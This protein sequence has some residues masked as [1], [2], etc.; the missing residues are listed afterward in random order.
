MINPGL[1]FLLILCVIPGFFA[2][3]VFNCIIK[4]SKTKESFGDITY[5]SVVHSSFIYIVVY[6]LFYPGAHSLGFNIFKEEDIIPFLSRTPWT[7]LIIVV[8]ILLISICYGVIYALLYR[9]ELVHKILSLFFKRVVEPP[10]ILADI[11]DVNYGT[12]PMYHWL[13]FKIDCTLYSGSITIAKLD[14]EPREFL[15]NNIA[16]LDPS[17]R[18]IM[19]EYQ[20]DEFIWL[21]V[22]ENISFLEIKSLPKEDDKKREWKKIIIGKIIDITNFIKFAFRLIFYL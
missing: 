8:I 22:D 10:N 13:T 19:Y 11:I 18:E 17:T 6:A 1:F 2:L 15:L 21:K 4:K 20:D 3:L 5:H 9:F 12:K 7:P 16:I 14:Q